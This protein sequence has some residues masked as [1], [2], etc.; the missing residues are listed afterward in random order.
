MLLLLINIRKKCKKEIDPKKTFLQSHAISCV[1]IRN[2]FPPA[3]VKPL[4][5]HKLTPT[6]SNSASTVHEVNTE[7]G[8]QDNSGF[9]IYPK[10]KRKTSLKPLKFSISLFTF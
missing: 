1:L 6:Q 5:E 2:M 9:L 10:G 4:M 8:I 7:S 3:L